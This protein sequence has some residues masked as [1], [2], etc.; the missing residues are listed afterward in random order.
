M[1]ILIVHTIPFN[2]IKANLIQ[3]LN[4]AKSFSGAGAKVEMAVISDDSEENLIAKLDTI[5][6]GFN[7]II[8][9][10]KYRE[11][12]KWM[13]PLELA[14]FISV[15][16]A[17][18]T[19]NRIIFTRSPYV[20][21]AAV[22]LGKKVIYES[23]NALF[24]GNVLINWFFHRIIPRFSYG[25]RLK[26]FVSISQNLSNYWMS[27]G[28]NASKIITLHDGV[29]I[30]PLPEASENLKTSQH[31]YDLRFCYAGSLYDDRKPERFVK[32]AGAFP[33]LKFVIVGG[34]SN[35]ADDLVALSTKEG[36][37]N[38]EF[39]G[40][41]PHKTVREELLKADVLLALWSKEVKTIDYCSP[42]KVFEY[43]E[44]DK[45]IV[46]EAYTTISEILT[47]GSNALLVNPDDFSSLCEMIGLI[48]NKPKKY[49]KMGIGNQELVRKN[50]SWDIRAEKILERL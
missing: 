33:K 19:T 28:I 49:L 8:V 31:E 5:I 44:V 18:F 21:V 37:R 17:I 25:N 48:Q 39:K 29:E 4:M 12:Y 46:A 3:T 2:E 6:N 43:M 47:D 45:L 11:R 30:K 42:L 32:L 1:R 26:M 40:P 20:V 35:K 24:A 36:I 34:P 16:T 50:Y 7:E 38:I 9:V 14:R 13:R 23:H 27:K 10:K 15:F 22:V 41:V